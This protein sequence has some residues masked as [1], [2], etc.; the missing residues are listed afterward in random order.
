MP[1]KTI[2]IPI[3]KIKPNPFRDLRL[4]PIDK[5][6]IGDLKESINEFGFFGGLVGRKVDGFV[7][8]CFGHSRFEALKRAGET[9]VE[10]LIKDFDDDEMVAV[11]VTENATQ[12]GSN[13]AAIMNECAAAMRRLV[14]IL[15]EMDFSRVREKY[16]TRL[17][18]GKAGFERA[19]GKLLARIDNPEKDG[20]LG[21]PLIRAYLGG[22]GAYR[23]FQEIRYAVATLKQ[24]AVYDT[25]V[26][27]AL[28]AYQE[29][30][31]AKAPGPKAAGAAVKP[32][33]QP[34]KPRKRTV[35][36]RCA[37]VFGN[38]NQSRA[39]Y[40]AVTTETAKR[41]IPVDQQF[42]LAKEIVVSIA[43]QQEDKKGAFGGRKNLG[44]P[45]IKKFVSELV[46]KQASKAQSKIDEEEK[47][48]L[49]EEQRTLEIRGE[50]KSANNAVR[51]LISSCLK[52][53]KLA[54]EF[55]GH[56][57]FGDFAGK[58]GSLIRSIEQLQKAMK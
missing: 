14:V 54:K 34:S 51:S 31:F 19:R 30:E 38:D 3:N 36:E 1:A 40:E 43:G 23:S 55:P 49:Y 53:E 35:D 18:D 37:A 46:V 4:F 44:G 2:P 15:L 21:E 33:K 27:D 58:L 5:A 26:D 32:R 39:F 9:S 48:K 52:L 8:L 47:R 11:M 42:A 28:V 41:F 56:I 25:I 22:D 12:S 10:V 50:I 17:F 16:G 29:R 20:G 13:P 24:S 45:Y 7:E 57:L 6:Q